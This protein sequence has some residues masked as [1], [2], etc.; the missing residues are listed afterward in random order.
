MRA[1]SNLVVIGELTPVATWSLRFE[2]GHKSEWD[3]ADGTPD[4]RRLSPVRK[5]R[6]AALS[7]HVPVRARS[8]TTGT[9]LLLESGLEL[10]LLS[11]LDRDPALIWIVPQPVELSWSDGV[12]HAPDLL[13]VDTGGSVILW[14]ARPERRQDDDF[15]VKAARTAVEC[16]RVGWSYEVFSGLSEIA[17]LN[18]RWLSSARRPP[19]WLATVR[20]EI[21]R[22]LG[23]ASKTIGEIQELDAGRGYVLPVFWHLAWVGEVVLDLNEVWDSAAQVCVSSVPLRRGGKYEPRFSN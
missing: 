3:W 17:S 4:L 20:P 1:Q 22:F 19:E 18:L 11:Q 13:A 12:R 15:Q 2:D 5:V 9:A 7:K 16:E 21:V 14:D 10:E 23:A 6:S 8:S